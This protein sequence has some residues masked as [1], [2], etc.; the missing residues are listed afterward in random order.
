M[1]AVGSAALPIYSTCTDL[2]LPSSP[3]PRPRRTAQDTLPSPRP[4]KQRRLAKPSPDNA[5]STARLIRLPEP[6][7]ISDIL[8]KHNRERLLVNPLQWTAQ[9][10]QLLECQFRRCKA[11]RPPRPTDGS[12]HCAQSDDVI[13]GESQQEPPQEEQLDERWGGYQPP[14]PGSPRAEAIHDAITASIASGEY[15]CNH[16]ELSFARRP[17]ANVQTD[18]VFG[19]ADSGFPT[20]AYLDLETHSQRREDYTI[21]RVVYMGRSSGS[22]SRT[23]SPVIRLGKKKLCHIKPTIE[24]EDPYMVAALIS[25]AQKQRDYLGE[26]GTKTPGQA[27]TPS[28]HLEP[29]TKEPQEPA[30]CYKVQFYLQA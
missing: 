18:G 14:Q 27:E 3:I 1:R 10:L 8:R 20:L 11:P 26:Q 5:V 22:R 4:L 28:S 12:G 21:P 29:T 2:Q 23:N 7:S 30:T 25:L 24:V 6:L 9:Q 13:G 15:P 17:V 19:H 16:V